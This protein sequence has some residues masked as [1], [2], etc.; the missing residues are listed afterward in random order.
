VEKEIANF[1]QQAVVSGRILV[2]VE[3]DRPN[4]QRSLAKAAQVLRE[5]GAK[6][7]PLPEG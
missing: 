2:A 7:L 6:P 1:Y 3:D 4:N 5:A